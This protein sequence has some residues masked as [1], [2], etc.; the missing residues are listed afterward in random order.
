MTNPMRGEVEFKVGDIAFTTRPSFAFVVDLEN[1]LKM[2]VLHLS[3]KVRTLS[4]S[5]TELVGFVH[6]AARHAAKPPANVDREDEFREAVF[7]A[8]PTRW[9]APMI[10]LV[11]EVFR[12]G[13]PDQPEKKDDAET[14]AAA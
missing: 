2:P 11:T 4:L 12:T 6:V 14:T 8:G 1:T 13:E 5:Y 7:Q 9:Y 3:A 10:A